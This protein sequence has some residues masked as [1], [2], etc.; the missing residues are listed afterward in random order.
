[1]EKQYNK[2]VETATELFKKYG[3]RSVSIDNVCEE[4]RI[5]KKT[6]YNYFAQKEDLVDA[7]QGKMEKQVFDKL[8]G[9][10]YTNNAINSLIVIIKEMKKAVDCKSD[11]MYYDLNKYYSHILKKHEDITQ[12]EISE[13]FAINIRQGIK[14]GY[15]RDNID[16]ELLSMFQ[17]LQLGTTFSAM[18]DT[19]QSY[20]KKRLLDFY[21]DLIIH[22]IANEKGLKYFEE[23]Y[24]KNE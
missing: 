2:I 16:I 1:M 8:R 7:V 3:I 6:F 17:A 15:Y 4:L 14:E 23:N 20:P 19:A 22:L 5:S 18:K 24:N 21:I 11:V 13:W 12:K 9:L 10:L